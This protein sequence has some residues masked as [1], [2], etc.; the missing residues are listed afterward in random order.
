MHLVNFNLYICSFGYYKHFYYLIISCFTSYNQ[1][2]SRT[3]RL[4]Y[5]FAFLSLIYCS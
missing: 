5:L 4:S 3:F 2:S 1:F